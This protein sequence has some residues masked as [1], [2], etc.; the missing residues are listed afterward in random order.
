[1]RQP[2]LPVKLG[3]E[4]MVMPALN[5]LLNGILETYLTSPSLL[6]PFARACSISGRTLS[7]MF[8]EVELEVFAQ[9]TTWIIETQD[10]EWLLF[11]RPGLVNR[12][13][14]IQSLERLFKI[15]AEAEPPAVLELL[16]PGRVIV[17]EYGRRWY[18]RDKGRLGLQSDP[19]KSALRIGCS[20]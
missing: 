3:H 6:Q 18:L 13:S 14:Q 16:E 12:R 1:L 2:E 8:S 20:S 15:E 19:C 10:G 9:G 5:L 17:V 7:G 11:P 4:K